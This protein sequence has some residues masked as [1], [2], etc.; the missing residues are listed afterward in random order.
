ML[1]LI[2][3]SL[4]LDAVNEASA[5]E[6]SIH[7]GHPSTSH[8]YWA[9]RPLAAVRAVIFASL[10][11]DPSEHPEKF[12]TQELQDEERERLFKILSKLVKWENINN[13]DLLAQAHE[14]ILKSFGNDEANL[15]ELLDPFAGGGSIPLEG[16]RLGLKVH[17]HDLNPVAVMIN[18]A[19]IE[20]P[21]N[22][23]D[24][25]PVNPEWRSNI[26]KGETG[27]HGTFGLASDV[28]YY[29]NRLKSEAYKN[30]RIYIRKSRRL[31]AT[32]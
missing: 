6:K 18:K 3:V 15:P 32:L 19:M 13:K 2:E 25:L 22:Y 26:D 17:A 24:E 10:V 20:I 11:D 14:E 28:E 31:K 5:K 1:K 29:A 8:L 27:A 21:P 30:S 16:Q 7:H 23:Y 9:R 4:P 12:P